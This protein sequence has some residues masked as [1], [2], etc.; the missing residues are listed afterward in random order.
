M[1]AISRWWTAPAYAAL[2]DPISLEPIRALRY[3]PF[4]LVADPSLPHWTSSDYFDG[5]TL[6]AYLVNTGNFS[7]PISRRDLARRG[8]ALDAYLREHSAALEVGL[9]QARSR[10]TARWPRCARRRRASVAL[11][12]PRPSQ[13]GNPARVAGDGGWRRRR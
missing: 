10:A 4:S 8:R 12:A 13:A 7:H 3:P 9:L 11:S 6:A 1:P 2:E 5:R